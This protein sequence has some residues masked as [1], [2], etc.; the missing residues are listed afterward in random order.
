LNR[1][2]SSTTP[3]LLLAPAHFKKRAGILPRP[4]VGSTGEARGKASLNLVNLLAYKQSPLPLF[5][6]YG[7][8]TL[9][10]GSR[11]C[12]AFYRPELS[13]GG[14]G[15]F[16]HF[17]S[18]YTLVKNFGGIVRGCSGGEGVSNA[19]TLCPNVSLAA[20]FAWT[21]GVST[22]GCPATPLL[23]RGGRHRSTRQV[24]PPGRRAWRKGFLAGTG[25]T[26]G[27][28]P[29]NFPPGLF[30]SFATQATSSGIAEGGPS[31]SPQGRG[32]QFWVSTG[33]DERPP[34]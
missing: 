16:S 15:H 5:V 33:S 4:I 20:S 10:S 8:G 34:S 7:G 17:I 29:L 32:L 30:L 22:A 11:H 14:L 13:M 25:P 6:L 1:N 23:L 3:A 21:R 2:K 9:S 18:F 24:R 26:A 19:H 12:G 31:C 28:S 27:G